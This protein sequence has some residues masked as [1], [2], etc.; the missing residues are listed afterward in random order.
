MAKVPDV[1]AG[2]ALFWAERYA[3]AVPFEKPTSLVGRAAF[4][5][6]LTTIVGVGGD[7][8]D[9]F[10]RFRHELFDVSLALTLKLARKAWVAWRR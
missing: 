6:A 4:K 3:A 7:A 9:V 1:V 2:T 10:D 5:F 8:C